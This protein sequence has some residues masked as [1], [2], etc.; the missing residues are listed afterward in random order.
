MTDKVKITYLRMKEERVCC[1]TEEQISRY[2][3]KDG[4]GDLTLTIGSISILLKKAPLDSCMD[5]NRLYL[6]SDLESMVCIPDGTVLQIKKTGAQEL[7]LGPIIGVFINQEKVHHLLAG[8][9]ITAYTQF[10]QACR[11]MYGLC[12]FFS[13]EGIDWDSKL[14]KGLYKYKSKWISAV[15]PLPRIIYDRNVENNCRI[16][17]L[18][19]RERLGKEYRI[20]NPMAKLGKWE[21]ICA[22]R[23]S[24]ELIDVI[25]ETIAYSSTSDIDH[26]LEK[27]DTV[28]LK[29]DSLSKG[30]GIFKLT[31]EAYDL[32]RVE[33]RT[34]ESNQVLELDTLSSL[35]ELIEDYS[36]K[37]GGYI[38]QQEIH[39]AS[40]KGNP[41]DFRLLYQKDYEGIWQ[42]GGI[43][44]RISAPG[45]IITSPRSGGD[46]ENFSVILQEAFGEDTAAK[47]GLYE[48]VLR[49]GREICLAIEKEFGNCV[50][51]GLDMT[52]DVN[53]KIWLIEVNGKPLKISLKRLNQPEIVY[54]CNMRPIEY[55]VYLS[56]FKAVNTEV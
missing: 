49:I 53:R 7:E 2:G 20:L 9:G 42:P 36:K 15:L 41:F 32:H 34:K 17:S 8:N 50:E 56:G 18:K 23:K 12:C 37:G 31:K 16:E 29:P 10:T 21:T 6:S 54:R 51:L 11:K 30:K 27:Y 45:S 5:A 14:I 13:I 38:I 22:L 44:G 47:N 33:Y 48:N 3:L 52:I 1:L 40:F 43:A 4:S 19:L 25:P 24:P 55:C 39:K 46:V 26:F 35:E 28:Y